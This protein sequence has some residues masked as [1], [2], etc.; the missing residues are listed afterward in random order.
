VHDARAVELFSRRGFQLLIVVP[1]YAK[2]KLAVPFVD[3][4]HLSSN[5]EANN[6]RLMVITRE[7]VEAQPS[8]QMKG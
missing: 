1:V 4:I 6:S 5:P 7:Q 2:A 3:T 8:E